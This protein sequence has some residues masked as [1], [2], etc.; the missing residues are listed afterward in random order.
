MKQRCAFVAVVFSVFFFNLSMV[1]VQAETSVAAPNGGAC[2]STITQSTSQAIILGNSIACSTGDPNYYHREGSFWRAFNMGTF[3]GSQQFNISSVSFG[4]EFA[5]SPAGGGQPATVR[6]YTNNGVAFPAG[7]RSE[8]ASKPI[9]IV[10]QQQE[11]LVVPITATVPAGT[12]ELVMEVDVP[13]GLLDQNVLFLGSNPVIQTGPSY[14]SSN[15]CGNGI[16]TDVATVGFPDVHWVF[17][18]NGVCGTTP[19]AKA[20]NLSTRLRVELGNSAMIGGFIINGNAPKSVVLRGMGPSLAGAGIP[21][22]LANPFLELHGSDGALLFSNNDWMDDPAQAA[23]IQGTIYQPTDNRESVMIQTLQPGAYT[24]VLNGQNQTTGV[25]LVEVYDNNQAADSQLS[26]LSTRGLVQSGTNVMIGGFILGA[27]PGGTHIAI[28]GIGP[29]LSEVGLSNVLQDPT[30]ELR[31]SNGSLITANDN[32]Q[33]NASMAT[34]L[35][36]HG[37]ALSNQV[38][39]GIIALLSPG[40][41]TVIL[42]GANSG[43]GIALMEIYNSQ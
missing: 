36:A 21:D 13:D 32:W 9:I 1:S 23:Q 24:A 30:L 14:V 40:P 34:E 10:N 5:Q 20:V 25:G 16:P 27:N 43:K 7:T 33:E 26:N 41:Y 35:T 29:S 8:I 11:I 39:S 4:I 31:D 6:L 15:T 12:E 18:V 28:R 38:E 42:A 22:V 19:T 2:S 17:N 37:L 3:T